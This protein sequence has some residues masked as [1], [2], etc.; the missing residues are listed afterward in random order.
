MGGNSA[1]A[2]RRYFVSGSV[3]GVGFRYFTQRTAS[4]L[5]LSGFVRN[6]RDGR[7]EVLAI[8]SADLLA[9]LKSE[10]ER[11]PGGATVSAV[12]EEIAALD[13]RYAVEFVVEFTTD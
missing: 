11:G 9:T 2:A 12:Y 5:G 13:S 10:L 3:Q 4:R 8:G 1:V 7:V 6:L